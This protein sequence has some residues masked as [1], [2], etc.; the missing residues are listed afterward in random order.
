MYRSPARYLAPLA[1]L[2][3]SIVIVL[4]VASGGSDEPASRGTKPSSAASTS[5]TTARTGTPR[6][7]TV[8]PGDILS[9]IADRTGVSVDRLLELNP[10]VDPQTLVP[11]QR[12]VLRR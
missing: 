12:L 11:G 2:A 10:S 5:T 3:C 7:Y 9:A 1:L 6:T 4:L 8:R